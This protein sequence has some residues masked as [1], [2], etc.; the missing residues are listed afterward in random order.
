M[1]PMKKLGIDISAWQPNVD[2]AKVKKDGYDFVILRAGYGREMSQKDS[3]FEKHYK[4]AKAAGLKVGAYWY[5]YAVDAA[6]ARKEASVCMEC[7]KGKVFEYPIYFDLEESSQIKKGKAFCSGLITAFCDALIAKGWCAGLYMSRSP[8]STVVDAS[9]KKQYPIWIAEYSV[10]APK[11]TG[12]YGMW[13]YSSLGSVAGITGN[14]D[15]N[16]CYEDYPTIIKQKGLNGYKPSAPS[17]KTDKID[18]FYKVKTANGWLP[19]VKNLTD[20]AGD[21]TPIYNIAIKVSKGKIKY[22]VHVKGGSWLPY[23]TG[24]NTAESVNGFAGNGQ[25]IDAVEIIF[26]DDKK[27][28]KYRVAPVGG[29]YFSYQKDNQKINGQDGYAGLYGRA[30]GKIQIEIA[31]G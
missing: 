26:V 9:I 23:V 28:A 31:G 6:D 3:C 27:Y 8:L 22:R 4:N 13:Q 12:E 11:Y 16:I 18:V 29:S 10:S 25:P 20:F 7:L 14:V 17:G 5:S 15:M 21:G 2:F 19:L 24:F 1:M 30:I